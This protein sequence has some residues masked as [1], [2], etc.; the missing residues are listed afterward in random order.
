MEDRVEEWQMRIN[1]RPRT[2]CRRCMILAV[3]ALRKAFKEMVYLVWGG[4]LFH[5]GMSGALVSN[6]Y[7][8]V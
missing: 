2:G 8:H 5:A 1:G 7:S 3:Y 6:L 4:V